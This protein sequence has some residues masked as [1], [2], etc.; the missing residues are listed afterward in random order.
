M[1]S[2]EVQ[3]YNLFIFCWNE[4]SV[5]LEEAE[6]FE[7]D[8]EDSVLTGTEIVSSSS[9]TLISRS[10]KANKDNKSNYLGCTR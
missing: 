7:L 9:C 10:S 2:H 1:R 6:D 4:S 8:E 3:S 5:E